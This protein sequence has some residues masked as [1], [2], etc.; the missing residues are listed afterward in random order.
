M[1]QGCGV[2]ETLSG[3]VKMLTPLGTRIH[4]P[5]LLQQGQA[6]SC[7]VPS[8]SWYIL[9]NSYLSP[10]YIP[11]VTPTRYYQQAASLRTT[12]SLVTSLAAKIMKKGRKWRLVFCLL[13]L[14]F[15]GIVIS[16]RNG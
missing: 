14:R 13:D 2:K 3:A 7:L 4:I 9:I 11:R 6:R 12:D 15:I 10:A 8:F 1:G 16:A 5:L